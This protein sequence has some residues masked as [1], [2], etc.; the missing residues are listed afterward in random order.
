MKRN[1]RLWAALLFALI[2]FVLS[3]CGM[4]FAFAQDED[5]DNGTGSGSGGEDEIIDVGD[6]V[7]LPFDKAKWDAD[8][9]VWVYTFKIP[10]GDKEYYL[11]EGSMDG[12]TSPDMVTPVNI[13][14]GP[15]TI[16]NTSTQQ[17]GELK[18]GKTVLI[19]NDVEDKGQK[20][21]IFTFRLTL[22]GSGITQGYQKFGNTVFTDGAAVFSLKHGETILFTGIPEGTA[23]TITENETAGFTASSRTLS[24]T[25]SAGKTAQADFV[26]TALK[27]PEQPLVDIV[28]K[29]RVEGSYTSA[30]EYEVFASF[31]GLNPSENY[32]YI[33]HETTDSGETT[34]EEIFKA[35]ADG[36]AT[37]SVTI[38]PDR[39]IVFKGIPAFDAAG[40]MQ[41]ASYSFTEQP[42]DY[43]AAYEI[44]N[45]GSSGSVS[46]S[47][48]ANTDVNQ[49]LST[50]TERAQEGEKVTVTFV[51]TI[52]RTVEIELTKKVDEGFVTGSRFPFV[53]TFGNLTPG[54]TV[55]R[56]NDGI[57]TADKDGV[58]V[59]YRDLS[60]GET[61]RF[62]NVPVNA[63]Y[64]IAES[65]TQGSKPS[66]EMT[67]VNG[68]DSGEAGAYGEALTTGK[69]T[70][71]EGK[72]IEVVFTNELELCDVSVTKT[73][74]DDFGV[75]QGQK[76]RFTICVDDYLTAGLDEKEG[77]VREAVIT[78][79]SGA[80]VETIELSFVPVQSG[81]EA[82]FTLEHGQTMTFGVL[83]GCSCT[84]DED[85]DSGQVSGYTVAVS[86]D[87]GATKTTAQGKT[88]QF[89]I[90][91]TYSVYVPKTSVVIKKVW[92]DGNSPSRPDSITIE[93]TASDDPTFLYI[94]TISKDDPSV[95]V[96]GNVWTFYAEWNVHD[97][98]IEE[99]K[100]G[101]YVSQISKDGN[102]FVITNTDLPPTGDEERPYLLLMLLGA[103]AVGAAILY[104]GR[105]RK[106][107]L[108]R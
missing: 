46:R 40:N 89:D 74:V 17:Y 32:V 107:S 59:F 98:L 82:A 45:A 92:N 12:Y 70:A 3:V 13:G 71:A 90:V 72:T 39:Y 44:V 47:N 103:S 21:E 19:P 16:V 80:V 105:R 18:V 75:S 86:G 61:Q 43:L 36:S 49:K 67:D 24:G 5:P 51:N 50:A 28:L 34:K 84:V 100:V 9:E 58:A 83:P 87:N 55:I 104:A 76:Y 48:D 57:V 29:K 4:A 20:N 42:G 31:S 8:Q 15:Y 73:V 91:N 38:S 97:Y 65:A 33:V 23:Y 26:N 2:W 63:T 7:R 81:Y 78:D 77:G 6:G 64:E 14:R 53:I 93:V 41:G 35:G 102:T 69:L 96:N 37:L 101:S 52:N 54:K 85:K 108:G 27:P 22:T 60:G 56:A 11:L 68:S 66:Y 99:F 30:G 106:R 1:K 10:G 25:I 95:V 79:A 88:T 62:T 94:K